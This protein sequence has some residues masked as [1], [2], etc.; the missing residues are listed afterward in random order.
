MISL[1][2]LRRSR[3]AAPLAIAI[4]L[5]IMGAGYTAVVP[6]V[7][8]AAGEMAAPT[9]EQLEQGE[10]LFLANCST[11]HGIGA[12][13]GDVAPSLIGVGAASVDFQVGT[14]RMPMGGSG[15]QAPRMETVEFSQEEIDA[16]A[17]YV[18]SLGAGPGVPSEDMVDPTKGDP[19]KGALAFRANCAMCH[20]FAG[21]GGALTRGKY[22]PTL[23]GVD[24]KYVYEA[25]ITGPQAMPVFKDTALSPESK[26]DIIAY[27]ETSNNTPAP[28][29][30]DLGSMGPVTEGLAAW[31]VGLGLLVAIAVWLGSKAA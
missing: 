6:T 11:C 21:M 20:N 29:G 12:V 9:A 15:P 28:G 2:A 13:G 30:Y 17:A 19:S 25:M 31:V 5:M 3:W 8:S 16:M 26:R 24:P 1:N 27:L 4:G 23:E 7:A 14:G 10:K 18:A 22:A